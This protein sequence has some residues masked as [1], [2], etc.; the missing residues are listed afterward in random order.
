MALTIAVTGLP[1]PQKSKDWTGL[2]KDRR[3]WF[4]VVFRP[5]SVFIRLISL[6]PVFRPSWIGTFIYITISFKTSPRMLSSVKNW[7]FF[8]ISLV[9]LLFPK[10]IY[11]LIHILSV[12]WPNIM[13]LGA[14]ERVFKGLQQTGLNRAFCSLGPIWLQSFSGYETGLLNT[15]SQGSR[16]LKGKGIG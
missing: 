10:V 13:L 7:C 1:F 9:H 8:K 16:V 5:V 6:W 11:I 14:F 2:Q 3:L 4:F 15:T 12:S